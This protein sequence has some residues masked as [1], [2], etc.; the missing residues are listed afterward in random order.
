MHC[1][2]AQIL[3]DEI[4]VQQTISFYRLMVVWLGGLIGGFK[5][6]LPS[7]CPIEFASMPEHFVEDAMEL[8]IVASQLIPKAFSGVLLDDFMNFIVMFMACPEYI[9][10]PYLRLKMVQ[11]LNCLMYGSQ[12]S[13]ALAM[14]FEGH[15]L[16]LEYLVR[17][18]LKPYV[19]IEYT[20]SHTQ[21]NDKF[22]IRHS[23]AELLKYL[24]QVPSHRN[25]WRQV[26]KEEEKGVYLNFLNF[27]MNDS[28]YLLDEG[29]KTIIEHKQ[30]EAEM[31]TAAWSHVPE[32]ERKEKTRLFHSQE[33]IIRTNM[34]FAN[35]DL[36]ILAFT[37][38]QITAPSY[39]RR[40]LK[41]WQACWNY[42]LLQLVG[43]KRNSLKL[44]EPEKYESDPKQLIKQIVRVY[45]HLARG[46]SDNIF[47]AA[48]SNDGRSYNDQLFSSA[49]DVLRRIG[50]D[51]RVI[52]EFI[53]LGSK[54]KDAASEAM[55]VEAA[56]GDIPDEFL[57]PIQYTLMKDPAI[58]PSSR[59]TID[60]P[61]I[62]RHLLSNSTD[63]F[64][65]SHLTADMLIPDIELKAKI[66]EFIRSQ[67]FIE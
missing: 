46:D 1:Y 49:V 53:E 24:W 67:E 50:E 36:S 48:I 15:K 56:L 51:G 29:F 54:A 9:R 62:Q 2:D 31:N 39:S 65:R 52:Q 7:T 17:N 40:W 22:S 30:L 10:N 26:A 13:A 21:F 58:L 38:E 11:V 4:L 63:P 61:V 34:I 41:V 64:N 25:V 23:I 19:D 27:L 60:R 28:I 59:I 14:L 45:A 37:S 43:R 16:S 57:D 18:L 42:F 20:G 47:A 32:H 33:N 55:D 44:T 6:R 12:S 3:K 5:M 66:Q 8:L 35:E